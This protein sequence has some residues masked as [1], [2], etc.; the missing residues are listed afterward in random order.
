MLT[1]QYI[2]GEILNQKIPIK[3]LIFGDASFY[4][5]VTF[6]VIP[7]IIQNTL[8]NVVSLLDNVMVGQVGTLPMS[9]VAIVNTLILIFYLCTWG[10]VSGAG[11]YGTQYYG[12]GDF[13]GLKNTLRFKIIL[14]TILSVLTI[15][16]FLNSGA[17]LIEL[18]ISNETSQS[19]AK[20]TMRLALQ[21]LHI[22]L[23]GLIPFSLTQCYAGTLRET[24]KTTLPMAAGMI[25][26]GVNFI[27]NGLLIFGL[28]VFPRLGVAGAAI[29]TVLSR[30]VELFIV[31]AASHNN[32][33]RYPFLEG[34]YR[35]FGVP[36]DMIV[37]LI[38]KTLPLL[39]NEMLWSMGQATLLQCYSIRGIEVIAAM[40]I[41]NTI[42][43]IFN[44]VF[45]SLGN[46]TSILVGQELGAKKYADSRKT[47]WRMLTLSIICSTAAGLVLMLCS[48]LIPQIYNTEPEIRTLATRFIMVVAGFMIVNAFATS[49]YFTL[50]SG[51]KTMITFLFDSCFTW[52]VSV[53]TA[54]ILTRFTALPV[55]AVFITVS[56]LEILKCV[57]G[58]ILVKKGVWIR[59]LVGG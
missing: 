3:E 9:A 49:A 22:M 47:A 14:T 23:I 41:S 35:Q 1:D 36:R 12:K 19:D 37:P 26:M 24:G 44:E 29:A 21:Y 10:A 8:T 33:K 27:F 7:M 4:R 32:R 34:L 54:F 30:F 50:R 38:S 40:N 42:S 48:P 53:S 17:T 25:A 46:A 43:Q 5:K 16:F 39:I 2:P 58:F 28:F 59:N 18:Y 57:V 51:G 45:L 31:V 11:I 20:E 55:L 15:V 56:A 52:T 13:E 6:V